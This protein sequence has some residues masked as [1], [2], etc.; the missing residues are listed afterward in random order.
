MT[1]FAI[2]RTDGKIWGHNGAKLGDRVYD[3]H[4]E[5]ILRPESVCQPATWNVEKWAKLAT[6]TVGGSVI[7]IE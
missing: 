5:A 3:W 2:Q 4:D 7:P 6:G 1:L